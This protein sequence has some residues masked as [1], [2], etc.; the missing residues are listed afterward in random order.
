MLKIRKIITNSALLFATLFM[1]D[2]CQKTETSTTTT[3]TT[4][5]FPPTDLTATLVSTTQVNLAWMDKSTNEVGFKVERKTATTNFALIATLGADI[6]SYNDNGLTPNTAYTYRVFS[7]NSVGAS[8]T[9]SNEVTITTIGI[10]VLTTTAVSDFTAIDGNSG[11]NITSDGGS[12]VTTRG[13]VWSTTQNP[14]ITLSTKTT[15]GSGTGTFTSKITGLSSTTKYYVRSYATNTAGTAYGNEVNFTTNTIDLKN[16]LVAFYPFSGNAGDSSGN[17]NHGTINGATLTTDR[18]SNINK[19]FSFNGVSHWIAV[20][21]NSV[22]NP[23]SSI[24]ISL[25]ISSNSVHNNSGIIGKWNN[26]NGV[27]ANGQE[28][29]VMYAGPNTQGIRFYTVTNLSSAV[30]D[31]N[32]GIK[33]N[34]G[35]WHNYTSTWDGTTM[36]LFRDGLVIDSVTQKGTLKSFNQGLEIGRYSGGSGTGTNVNYFNG[37]IDDVRIYNRSLNQSE[38]TY[39]ATH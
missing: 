28:Q 6:T 27:S 9:Y 10:P 25:W 8:P 4:V 21:D 35:A 11:G 22:L 18:F 23:A 26:F 5:P 33:Y 29:Y 12:P 1:F 3:V 15:D 2:S 38:I 31:E 34:D 39:L 19:S 20:K 24:S 7:Y 17:G 14:T 37:K 13:V 30:V 36:K 16:G 32:K